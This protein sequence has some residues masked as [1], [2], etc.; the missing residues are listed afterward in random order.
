MANLTVVHNAT[1]QTNPPH[2]SPGTSPAPSATNTNQNNTDAGPTQPEVSLPERA[3]AEPIAERVWNMY[4]DFCIGRLEY[5]NTLGQ[6][7]QCIRSRIGR[8]STGHKV[9]GNLSDYLNPELGLPVNVDLGF[10]AER[11]V[12]RLG[13]PYP[14]AFRN[15]FAMRAARDR[16]AVQASSQVPPPPFEGPPE[17]HEDGLTVDSERT[18]TFGIEM[19]GFGISRTS[20]K[21]GE[22]TTTTIRPVYVVLGIFVRGHAHPRERVVFVEKPE[23]LFWRMRWAVVRMRGWTGTFLSL[24]HVKAFR[25]YKVSI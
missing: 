6:A 17:Y 9:G 3:P 1:T 18:W 15:M 11:T 7:N 16:A 8:V 21:T 5:T 10:H 13:F 2:A 19:F 20:S 14:T 4:F 12:E 24:R 25:L 23:E 22:T